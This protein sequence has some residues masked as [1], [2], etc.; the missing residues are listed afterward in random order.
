M[1]TGQRRRWSQ[2]IVFATQGALGWLQTTS[3]GKEPRCETTFFGVYSIASVEFSS[4]KCKLGNSESREYDLL[5]H[6]TVG[7]VKS[8]L[9][10]SEFSFL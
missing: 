6:Y 9:A 2:L 7:H 3:P 4:I 5:G 8:H 1:S 10:G